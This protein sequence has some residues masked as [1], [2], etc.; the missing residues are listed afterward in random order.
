MYSRYGNYCHLGKQF[1]GVRGLPVEG[2]E[3]YINCMQPSYK[4]KTKKLN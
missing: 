4:V 1:R 2:R 3:K